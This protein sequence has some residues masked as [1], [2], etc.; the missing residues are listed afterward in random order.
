MR[1]K[2]IIRLLLQRSVNLHAKMHRN[3][4]AGQLNFSGRTLTK[5]STVSKPTDNLRTFT[6]LTCFFHFW[7]LSRLVGT[8]Q[9]SKPAAA[10]GQTDRQTPDSCINPAPQC[11]YCA[12]SRQYDVHLTARVKCQRCYV[13]SLCSL[14]GTQ[15]G[16]VTSA[17][18][19]VTLC[20]PVWHVSS[21]S[22]VATV[23]TAIHLL[24]TVVER[25]HVQSQCSGEAVFFHT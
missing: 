24:L 17:E 13:L 11:A 23:R 22:G 18:W 20:D 4:H 16:N 1:D 19:Q 8:L 25:S 14:H 12:Q 9:S 6:G 5:T 7:N 10:V 3:L 2:T 15:G 21:R